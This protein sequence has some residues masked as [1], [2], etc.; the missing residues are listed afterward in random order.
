M[1][2][3]G[4]VSNKSMSP[5]SYDDCPKTR[6]FWGGCLPHWDVLGRPIFL[7]LHVHGAIPQQ[8]AARIREQAAALEN[9][10]RAEVGYSV[11]HASRCSPRRPD[12]GGNAPAG[13]EDRPRAEVGH[14][15]SL[16]NRCSPRRPDAGP[17]PDACRQDNEYT[18]RLKRVF[19]NMETWLD[20]ADQAP[21]LTHD[22]VSAMLRDAIEERESRGW[23]RTL[24]WVV[25]PSHVH[26]LYIGGTEGMKALMADFK[27]W[28]GRQAA[29]IL[30]RGGKPFWQEEWF[31]HWSRSEDET[32]RIA[33]YIRENPVKAGLV[34]SSER[35][36]HASWT[37]GGPAL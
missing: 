34:T 33:S 37:T 18:R 32:D 8:A 35:W 5:V 23:W 31:D 10:P 6:A 29:Q 12:A 9:R 19:R 30:D 27:R 36:P 17:R 3:M 16:V 4:K 7:T 20:R 22:R 25:M 26:I 24:H 21:L 28:T 15:A 14:G 11:Q 1:T 13:R 2:A